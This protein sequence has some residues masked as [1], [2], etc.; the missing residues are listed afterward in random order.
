MQRFL[1][2]GACA[3]LCACSTSNPEDGAGIDYHLPRTDVTVTMSLDV[4]SCG[5]DPINDVKIKSE[6]K[7]D[8]VA[9]AQAAVYHLSGKDLISGSIKRKIEVAVDDNGVISSVNSTATDE[10]TAII[11]SFVKIAATAVAFG[12]SSQDHWVLAC[13]PATKLALIQIA[14]TLSHI[15]RLRTSLATTADPDKVQQQINQLAAQIVTMKT[16]IHRDISVKVSLE[17]SW[18][19]T[20]LVEFKLQPLDELLVATNVGPSGGAPLPPSSAP[21]FHGLDVEAHFENNSITASNAID[22]A[23]KEAPSSC[24]QSLVVPSPQSVT[25]IVEP[26]GEYF[27]GKAKT[28]NNGI[29]KTNLVAAQLAQPTKLCISARLGEDRTINLKFNKFGQVNDFTWDAASQVA[30]VTGALAGAVPDAAKVVTT[31]EGLELAK[32]KAELERLQTAQ[33]LKKAQAC[34]ALLDAGASSCP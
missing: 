20:K 11:G 2:L 30:N 13:L 18:K 6:F 29:I 31:G 32:E 34:Q 27:S 5:T 21:Q 16:L 17:N 4:T 15:D 24:D 28:A 25:F 23:S 19:D 26:A 3:F 10:T 12:S 22:P 1:F 14:G 8:V 33:A 9:G 7:S